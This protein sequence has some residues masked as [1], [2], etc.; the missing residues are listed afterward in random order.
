M[1][2]GA[3]AYPDQEQTLVA[4]MTFN[5]FTEFNGKGER[6]N[7]IQESAGLNF[8]TVSW[9]ERLKKFPG[10]STNLTVGAGPTQA[11]PTL[12][13][14]NDVT[15][16]LFGNSSVPVT[17][18]REA[19]DFMVNGTL[20]RWAKL[21]GER[22]V[23]FMS[24]GFAAGSLY[25]EAFAQMGLRRLS[26]AE[27][28][29]PVVGT[30]TFLRGFSQFVRFS[31]MG[32]Y[33]QLFGGAAFRDATVAAQNYLGQVSMSIAS[34]GDSDEMPPRW[35]LEFAFTIDSGL[36]ADPS[37]HSIER[38]LG[39]VAL[40]FP[41]GFLE[42]WNDGIGGTDS[43]PTFGFQIMIDLRRIYKQVTAP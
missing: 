26:L 29:E 25:Q 6:F 19:T 8:A 18:E 22:E 23:G 38:R 14:Q 43:G 11:N 42:T 3:I 41:Y 17:K 28:L 12:Y 31:G 24:L 30:S 5:R 33:G 35:E 4:G 37:G 15:H 7:A 32:R 20:T 13:L 16:Q 34:Y 40:R 36:F 10:W 21:F 9:T 2:W 39:S 27:A 1:H